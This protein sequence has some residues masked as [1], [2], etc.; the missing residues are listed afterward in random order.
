MIESG[1]FRCSFAYAGTYGH[2]CGK[3]AVLTG[4]RASKYTKSGIYF[5]HRCIECSTARGID[6]EWITQWVK[7]DPTLHVNDFSRHV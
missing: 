7:L 6:N 4:K 5:A 3:P 2:E 1:K